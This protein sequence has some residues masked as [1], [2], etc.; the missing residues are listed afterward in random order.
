MK[1]QT[2]FSCLAPPPPSSRVDDDDDDDGGVARSKLEGKGYR[3]GRLK[4]G[5]AQ[6]AEE[7][8][9]II[10][11]VAITVAWVRACFLP[12]LLSFSLSLT[13]SSLPPQLACELHRPWKRP[14]ACLF[15]HGRMKPPPPPPPPSAIPWLLSPFTRL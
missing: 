11:T 6:R 10:N 13:L 5:S 15:N 3:G 7:C 4:R 9:T 1:T 12:L 14:C 8:A 2:N